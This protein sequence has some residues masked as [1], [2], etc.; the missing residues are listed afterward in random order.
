MSTQI[1]TQTLQ[2]NNP[3]RRRYTRRQFVAAASAFGVGL[4]VLPKITPTEVAAPTPNHSALDYLETVKQKYEPI[5]AFF[6]YVEEA[7]RLSQDQV[8]ADKLYQLWDKAEVASQKVNGLLSAD[9]D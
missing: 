7:A 9:W 1:L 8:D 2:S 6:A 3:K 5:L 4:P